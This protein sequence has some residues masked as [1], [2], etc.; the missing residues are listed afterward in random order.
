MNAFDM[1]VVGN[2]HVPHAYPSVS[3][4]LPICVLCADFVTFLFSLFFLFKLP[5]SA[6]IKVMGN[7]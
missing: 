1:A 5:L 3:F 2:L 4:T 6:L 7:A